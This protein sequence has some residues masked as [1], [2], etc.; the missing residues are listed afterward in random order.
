[1]NLSKQ[2]KKL[3]S[4]KIVSFDTFNSV[5]DVKELSKIVE[6]KKTS[7]VITQESNESTDDHTESSKESSSESEEYKVPIKKKKFK[8]LDDMHKVSKQSSQELARQIQELQRQQQVLLNQETSQQKPSQQP[9]VRQP[10][11]KS[12]PK[13][14]FSIIAENVLQERQLSTSSF[15][16]TPIIPP[17]T[18]SHTSGF[19]MANTMTV[20]D[21]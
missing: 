14:G 20:V 17:I 8:S 18:S 21:Y 7:P 15:S 6:P 2:K 12:Q 3:S 16:I 5:N 9:F 1:M 19:S 10:V 4:K 13:T 11:Y